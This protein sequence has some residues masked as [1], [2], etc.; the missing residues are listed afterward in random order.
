MAWSLFFVVLLAHIVVGVEDLWVRQ[1]CVAAASDVVNFQ[2]YLKWSNDDLL[3]SFV[4]S[5]CPENLPFASHKLT[6]SEELMSFWRFTLKPSQ[7]AFDNVMTR[8]VVSG[9][10]SNL[11]RTEWDSIHCTGVPVRVANR[12]FGVQLT[13]M[14][15][16]ERFYMLARGVNSASAS[17]PHKTNTNAPTTAFPESRYIGGISLFDPTSVP[18]RRSFTSPTTRITGAM[19]PSLW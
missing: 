5:G 12:V 14:F 6:T 16:L 10:E 9:V 1:H 8:L 18:I 2:I 15:V 7:E 13:R 11:C 19:D 4:Q 17:L 3:T